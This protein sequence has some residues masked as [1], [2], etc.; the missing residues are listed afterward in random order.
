MA[1]RVEKEMS[2]DLMLDGVPSNRNGLS[3]GLPCKTESTINR[4]EKKTTRKITRNPAQTEWRENPTA[5]EGAEAVR[6]DCH[7]QVNSNP[8]SLEK[9]M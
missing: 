5:F 1:S 2:G 3:R 6:S 7:R 9:V 8:G 4:T